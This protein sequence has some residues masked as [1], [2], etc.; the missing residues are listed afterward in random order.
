MRANTH[1]VENSPL[2]SHLC[3]QL[4]GVH[5]ST[6]SCPVSGLFCPRTQEYPQV[7]TMAAKGL[8]QRNNL[9]PVSC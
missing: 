8:L 6:T 4:A 5:A 2:F 3:K 7:N 1:P 9:C